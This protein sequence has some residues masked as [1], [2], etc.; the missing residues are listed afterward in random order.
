MLIKFYLVDRSLKRLIEV[1]V[2]EQDLDFTIRQLMYQVLV[3]QMGV[4][5]GWYMHYGL[6]A[7]RERTKFSQS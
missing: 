3:Q 6:W 5:K 7:V 4:N 2:D 1:Q